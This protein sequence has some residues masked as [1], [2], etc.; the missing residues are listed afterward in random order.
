MDY[1]YICRPGDNEELRYSIRSVLANAP[2]GNIWVVGDKPD[3]YS[4]N[5]I[6]VNPKSSK[7]GNAR[8]NI[9]A[10][11]NSTEISERFV[12]MN[13][14]FFIVKPVKEIKYFYNGKMKNII[15]ALE[16]RRGNAG[17][18]NLLRKTHQKLI[19]NRI[20]NPLNYELH[21]PM[22]MEKEKLNKIFVQYSLWRSP[23]GNIYK[24]GG[25][26]MRDVKY[27]TNPVHKT[28]FHY[29]ESDLPYLSTEDDSF[30]EVLPYLENLFPNPSPYELDR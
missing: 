6:Y 17:Y 24:V 1:V 25:E 3:W 27:H 23:Y 2:E 22:V 16:S 21:I 10:I 8:M 19:R 15:E 4:G 18:L 13:D 14:D 29:L 11:L 28:S 7:Y 26:Y 12:L 9:E 20:S 5:H 30:E